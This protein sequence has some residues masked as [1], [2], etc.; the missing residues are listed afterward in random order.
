MQLTIL[1]N[2]LFNFAGIKASLAQAGSWRR[3]TTL[4][5]CS[6]SYTGRP[7]SCVWEY[8]TLL[9]RER[10]WSPRRNA[11]RQ[12]KFY[13]FSSELP[14]T[15]DDVTLPP[16]AIDIPVADV[17]LS[18]SMMAQDPLPPVDVPLWQIID[19]TSE[20]GKPKIFHSCG[21]SFTVKRKNG[22]KFNEPPRSI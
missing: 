2:N 1:F 14:S 12:P 22:N 7:C 20:L 21:Y 6:L 19:S 13:F 8:K 4:D 17:S 9:I 18:E 10:S 11:R 3:N 15:L 5:L 16:D